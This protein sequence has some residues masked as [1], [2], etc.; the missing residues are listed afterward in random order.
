MDFGCF[1][2]E[3]PLIVKD[4][5]FACR[6]LDAMKERVEDR[7]MAYDSDALALIFLVDVIDNVESALFE[8]MRLLHAWKEAVG[9]N[10][11][12]CL[13]PKLAF[14][15]WADIVFAKTDVIDDFVLRNT[16]GFG[17]DPGC[18]FRTLEIRSNDDIKALLSD[19]CRLSFSLF[20]AP[21]RERVFL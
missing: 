19:F 11:L 1:L 6:L 15:F 7:A 17:Q 3:S 2:E 8:L 20:L 18:F 16:A 12:V 5:V 14:P 4:L 10:V 9:S 13:S 21:V